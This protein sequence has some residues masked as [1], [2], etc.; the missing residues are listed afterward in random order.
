MVHELYVGMAQRENRLCFFCD[1]GV[2]LLHDILTL[3]QLDV[4]NIFFKQIPVPIKCHRNAKKW[5]KY[6]DAQLLW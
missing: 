5:I 1:T 3:V 4:I 6:F 2:F